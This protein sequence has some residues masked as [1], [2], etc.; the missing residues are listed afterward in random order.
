VAAKKKAAKK[1]SAKR[2]AK[3]SVKRS[4]KKSVKKSSVKRSVKKSAKRSAKSTTRYSI[5]AVPVSGSSRSSV[6]SISTTPRPTTSAPRSTPTSKSSGSGSSKAVVVAVVVGIL[7]LA[8]A[9]I[10]RNSSSE[11]TTVTP[12]PAASESAA[13]TEQPTTQSSGE[14][15]TA[16]EAP[17]GIVSI[18]NE[19]GAMVN[20]KAPAASAGIT[21][22][23]VE[24]RDNGVGEWKLVATVP[25]TQFNQQITKNDTAGWVQV[26][27]S[28][29]YADG[30][31]V[32]GKIHGLPGSW[33]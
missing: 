3:K 24:L 32:A 26:K 13:P 25:A 2:S 11:S 7:V 12:T 14:P 20:W 9:V 17:V 6:S 10:S 29:V 19:T 28:T 30:E 8:I 21:G 23:N 16:Y 31:V 4:V 33:S 5:P 1:A 15:I 18:Y 27:V 22:Y